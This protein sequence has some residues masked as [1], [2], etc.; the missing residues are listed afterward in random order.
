MSTVALGKVAKQESV[1]VEQMQKVEG[2]EV[3]LDPTS[4]SIVALRV[5][6][7]SRQKL[8]L[9][10]TMSKPELAKALKKY[11]T[12]L[13]ASGKPQSEIT[14][15]LKKLQ[16]IA[17]EH[18]IILSS[19]LGKGQESLSE[20]TVVEL[21][22]SRPVVT[23][24][25]CHSIGISG[26]SR[27]VDVEDK[28][29][30][31]ALNEGLG[32]LHA[33]IGT[34]NP[35][36]ASFGVGENGEP[37]IH[38][39][40]VTQDDGSKK[41]YDMLQKDALEDLRRDNGVP[42]KELGLEQMSESNKQFVALT[43]TLDELSEKISPSKGARATYSAN[44]IGNLEGK[45]YRSSFSSLTIGSLFNDNHFMKKTVTKAM[46]GKPSLVKGGCLT[47]HGARAIKEM[48]AASLYID[49]SYEKLKRTALALESGIAM[50]KDDP[51]RDKLLPCPKLD[52]LQ[53]EFDTVNGQITELSKTDKLAV[54]WMIMQLNSTVT[55]Y[56]DKGQAVKPEKT[57]RE[58]I[59]IDKS[60]LY[61]DGA[62]T[63][64]FDS[65]VFREQMATKSS[66]EFTHTASKQGFS[67]LK[68]WKSSRTVE[69]SE[70]NAGAELG[71]MF[72]Y[73][74]GKGADKSLR[75]RNMLY[76]ERRNITLTRD[77][78]GVNWVIG[79]AHDIVQAS[80]EKTPPSLTI[81]GPGKRLSKDE[82]TVSGKK[83]NPYQDVT[84]TVPNDLVKHIKSLDNQMKGKDASVKKWTK[85]SPDVAIQFLR[86]QESAV[87]FLGTPNDDRWRITQAIS[88]EP[89]KKSAE[90]DPVYHHSFM[91]PMMI[92]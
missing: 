52:E 3:E 31:T 72:F 86:S 39:I 55:L 49:K 22:V 75:I 53:K 27:K 5:D 37:V 44:H 64:K 21:P 34:E 18:D 20:V 43:K 82:I 56:D 68:F 13:Q 19:T 88:S 2:H 23:G 84:Q 81:E 38:T 48:A 59:E 74:F 58:A 41:H 12:E 10:S 67:R 76:H 92:F 89:F 28:E 42:E 78:P 90:I 26:P 36:T 57:V 51:L 63:N 46:M 60:D 15:A 24:S 62:K 1:F 79:A 83:F 14:V 32:D 11:Q 91:F 47:E 73:Q 4:V 50:I 66:Q 65:S 25:L 29:L 54:C 9:V 69:K 70:H 77:I 87:K 61:F 7:I 6:D 16:D 71:S 30:Q 80:G 40:T 35:L 8:G 45:D 85:M 17:A 33:L